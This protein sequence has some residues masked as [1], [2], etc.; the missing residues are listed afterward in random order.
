[1]AKRKQNSVGNIFIFIII[2]VL[3]LI[4]LAAPIVLIIGYLYNKINADKIKTNLSGTQSDFWLDEE[5]KKDFKEKVNQ[6]IHVNGIIEKANQRGIKAGISR[7]QDGSF[8][9]RS[10]LGKEILA[11]FAEYEPIKSS[12]IDSSRTLQDLPISRWDEF[13]KFIKNKKSFMFAF[14]S[15]AIVLIVSFIVLGKQSI[16]DIFTPYIAL[17]TNFFRS[18]ASQL[19]LS[20]GDIKMIAVA[21]LVAIATYFITG[22]IFKSS[23][24]KYTPRPEKVTLGNVD[25]Y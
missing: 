12:L 22:L 9:A 10:N 6:L 3:I 25:L 13:N 2:V 7:N 17:A 4:A 20:D 14:I 5:E 19:P 21:T 23:G 16:L 24:E 1:M 15:W 11:T 18:T 8:S